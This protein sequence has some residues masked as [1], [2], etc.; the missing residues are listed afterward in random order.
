SCVA[1]QITQQPANV[2]VASGTTT[3]LTA[4]VTGTSLTYRWYQGPVFDFTKP[5]GGNNPSLLTPAITTPAEFW[6]H[7]TNPCGTASTTA[8]QVTPVNPKRRAI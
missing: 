8:V 3:K 1:P 5:V 7:V 4:N 2:T 6:L